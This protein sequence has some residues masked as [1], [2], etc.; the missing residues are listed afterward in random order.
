MALND[1]GVPNVD[2][3]HGQYDPERQ[4]EVR[5]AKL[6]ELAEQGAFVGDT[7]EEIS[8]LATFGVSALRAGLDMCARDGSDPVQ[9]IVSAGVPLLADVIGAALSDPA[10]RQSIIRADR[11][12][13]QVLAD[14]NPNDGLTRT[15]KA[16]PNPAM[17][18]A[19]R[20]H[21]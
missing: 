15:L 4:F 5:S 13:A 3:T 21:G 16:R 19:A 6:A 12:H 1:F 18:P 7:A 11:I 9:F 10:L 17:R 20:K 2:T 8:A 14:L